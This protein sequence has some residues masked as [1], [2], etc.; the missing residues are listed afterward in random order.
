MSKRG[1]FLVTAADEDSA[2]LR[3][4]AAG[5]VHAL[6]SNPDVE[7]GDVLDATIAPEPPLEVTW[8]VEDV[9]AR[10]SVTVERVDERPDERAREAAADLDVGEIATLE[11][12]AGETH[13]IAV[14]P[15]RTAA[16]ADEVAADDGTQERAASLGAERVSVRA[17]DGVVSVR[18]R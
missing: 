13:V 9:T 7:E 16:A 1:T 12:H 15:E 14:S 10:R 6:A 2:V 4:V 17:A 18:Y 11:S 3:D 5:Q 8:T